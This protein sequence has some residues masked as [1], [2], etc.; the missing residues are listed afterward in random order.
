ML[1]VSLGSAAPV[2][3]SSARESVAAERRRQSGADAARLAPVVERARLGD[4]EA[5]GQLYDHYQASVHRIIYGQTRSTPLTE[6]LTADTFFRA[7]RGIRGFKLDA[8]LF[9]AWLFRIARNLVIDHFKAG[10]TRFEQAQDMTRHE[11]VA[12]NTDAELIALL[13]RERVRAALAE[14]PTGQRRV[15]E[16]RFLGELSISEVADLL[17]TTEGAVKQLQLRGL[18]Y[19][20]R[21]MRD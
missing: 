18:R 17:D 9:P 12:D 8:E 7:L 3:G 11:D 5:F 21:T 14:L 6:D 16:L 13:N 10:R 1:A 19:L 4:A 15:I 2:S 20:A